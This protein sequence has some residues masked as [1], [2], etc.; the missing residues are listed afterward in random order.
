M[1]VCP[2]RYL[3]NQLSQRNR[4]A[5]NVAIFH[6][7]HLIIV[8]VVAITEKSNNPLVIYRLRKLA[9]FSMQN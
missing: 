5:K 4:D 6:Q 9:G 8:A 7:S 3:L 2:V 1:P